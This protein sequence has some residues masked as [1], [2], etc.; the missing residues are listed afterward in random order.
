LSLTLV[1]DSLT[2]AHDAQD[3]ENDNHHQQGACD[4]Y[5]ENQLVVVVQRV[6][7]RHFI[8]KRIKNANYALQ[9]E[10][11]ITNGQ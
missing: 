2:A 4:Y 1:F 9:K 8:C 5:R 10:I 6:P 7:P 3:D 11:S